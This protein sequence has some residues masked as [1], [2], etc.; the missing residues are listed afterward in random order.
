MIR[1]NAQILV[2]LA[3]FVLTNCGTESPFKR[4][5][6]KNELSKKDS[7]KRGIPVSNPEN[8]MVGL[9]PLSNLPTLIYQQN[10]KKYLDSGSTGRGLKIAILDNGF[11][12][13]K[14]SRGSRLPPNTRLIE[15]PGNEMTSSP[16]GT[17][18]AEI[19]YSLATGSAF[20]TPKIIGPEIILL[21]TN[22]YSNLLHA[23]DTVILEQV[24]IVLYA[25]VWEYGGNFDGGG[26]INKEVDRAISSGVLWVNAAGNMGQSTWN[27]NIEIDDFGGVKLPFKNYSDSPFSYLRFTVP[28]DQTDV[29]IVLSWNDFT[30]SKDH[31][32]SQDLNLE[33]LDSKNQIIDGSYLI[34]TGLDH[35]SKEYSNHAREIVHATLKPGIYNIRINAASKNFD[36]NSIMRVTVNGLG[37][38]L[39]ERSQITTVLIPADNPN[40]LTV[41]ATD[42]DYSGMTASKPEAKMRS[43]VRFGLN[44]THKGTSAATAIAVGSLATYISSM[45]RNSSKIKKLQIDQL[46]QSGVLGS[47]L[48]L[49]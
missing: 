2:L 4:D 30:N 37:V 15:A 16:H 27:G 44:Q 29:K 47:N 42:V 1:A 35:S 23:I 21:N 40:V 46:I 31:K 43:E 48:R 36:K 28:Q 8:E 26:F 41:G 10:L 39:I 20:Y 18:M 22:G 24:D 6:K 7:E 12:G 9:E 17:K 32:T 33:L 3:A 45:P 19:V 13:L 38:R 49:P 5:E 34:Q 14:Y 11:A 25:Q